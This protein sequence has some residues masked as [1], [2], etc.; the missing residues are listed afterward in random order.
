[1]ALFPNIDDDTTVEE[2][3][4][5]DDLT[6]TVDVEPP[7]PYGATWRFDFDAG[8]IYFSPAGETSRISGPDTVRE[9][10]NHT[11]NTARFE[12][13]LMPDNTGTDIKGLTG[14]SLGDGYVESRIKAEIIE[15][16]QQHDRIDSVVVPLVFNI[17]SD[18][19]AY[20]AYA[21][22]DSQ[23]IEDTLSL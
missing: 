22:D 17:G 6:E 16:F 3:F 4:A 20:I 8:D 11:V 2:F 14:H 1:M 7:T 13:S 21:L 19:F 23:T 15:G 9:W 12:T 18:L 10:I 5:D